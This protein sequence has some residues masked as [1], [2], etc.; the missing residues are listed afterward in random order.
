MTSYHD[1]R[2]AKSIED[3]IDCYAKQQDWQK[4]MS[5]LLSHGDVTITLFAE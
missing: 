2:M 1:Y 5:D 3:S 4:M